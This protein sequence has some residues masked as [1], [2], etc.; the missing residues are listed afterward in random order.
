MVMVW[1]KEKERGGGALFISV[2]LFQM[3]TFI[4]AL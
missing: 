2:I 3:L 4:D 1:E